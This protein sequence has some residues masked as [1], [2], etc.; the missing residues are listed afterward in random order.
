MQ[1]DQKLLYSNDLSNRL[2]D[3]TIHRS[4]LEVLGKLKHFV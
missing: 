2:T 4:P 3:L 1:D